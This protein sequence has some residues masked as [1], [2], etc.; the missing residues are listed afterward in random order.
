M[1]REFELMTDRASHLTCEVK[2]KKES[3]HPQK[4]L[5]G[6]RIECEAKADLNHSNQVTRFAHFS[7]KQTL[8]NGSCSLSRF[9]AHKSVHSPLLRFLSKRSIKIAFLSLR[10]SLEKN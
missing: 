5:R 10:K 6:I 2:P 1:P 9:G 3:M 8:S 7:F 4:H